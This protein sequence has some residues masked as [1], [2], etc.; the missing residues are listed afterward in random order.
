MSSDNLYPI[1]SILT[2]VTQRK[3]WSGVGC[4]KPMRDSNLF[5]YFSFKFFRES[6]LN[7]FQCK[8]LNSKTKHIMWFYFNI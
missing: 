7:T 6:I 2:S 1:T 4:E 8:I 5:I 3:N